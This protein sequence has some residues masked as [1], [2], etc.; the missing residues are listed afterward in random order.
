MIADCPCGWWM[1]VPGLFSDQEVLDAPDL[2]AHA[3]ACRVLVGEPY[4]HVYWASW[5]RARGIRE[6]TTPTFEV[7]A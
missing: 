2:V 4:S 5:R 7:P 3:S 1:A 6:P